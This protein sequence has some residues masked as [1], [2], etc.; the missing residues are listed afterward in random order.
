MNSACLASDTVPF[1]ETL[2][3]KQ[4]NF[5]NRMATLTHFKVSFD[6]PSDIKTLQLHTSELFIMAITAQFGL[7]TAS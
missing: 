3:Y 4:N 1:Y 7:N 2:F 5:A 6:F